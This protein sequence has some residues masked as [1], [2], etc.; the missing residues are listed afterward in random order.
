M[1]CSSVSSCGSATPVRAARGRLA[2][3]V[4]DVG[5]RQRDHLD[6]VAVAG[7]V[8]RRSRCPER[9]APGEH[10]ADPALLEHVRD[11]VAHAGLQPRVGDLAEAVGVREEVGRLRGVA[12]PELD[13]VDAVERHEVLVSAGCRLGELLL[14][15]H[16]SLLIG[17]GTVLHHQG[18][19]SASVTS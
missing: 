4:L 11:A 6:A 3:G 17:V 14:R 19:G 12:D 18:P 15:G 5:H 10:E 1:P 8:A 16:L 9:S 7:V 13:V 2:V